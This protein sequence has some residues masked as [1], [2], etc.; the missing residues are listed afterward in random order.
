MDYTHRRSRQAKDRGTDG[1][2]P[3]FAALVLRHAGCEGGSSEFRLDGDTLAYWCLSCGELEVFAPTGRKG[4]EGRKR[5]ET[6]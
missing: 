3:A 6:R 4:G 2:A 5:R 1:T